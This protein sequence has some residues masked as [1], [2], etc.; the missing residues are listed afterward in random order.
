[1]KK[2]NIPTAK[3]EVFDNP[4]SAIEY[5]VSENTVPVVVKADG[6]ALGKGVI[7]AQTI[8][9][10]KD[11][12]KSIME[13]KQFG[14]SGN[15]IVI[16]EFLKKPMSNIEMV[17]AGAFIKNRRKINQSLV[18]EIYSKCPNKDK[19]ITTLAK[20]I[21]ETYETL[22]DEPEA[23]DEGNAEWEVVDLS[24]KKGQK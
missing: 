15:N 23:G 10:A 5:V 13:D 17:F 19:L 12:I 20:M 1:M 24:L 16:E 4:K 6:L 9:E 7:I 22:F 11:A 2:Y 18:E 21:Q 8:D 3:Y 14:D